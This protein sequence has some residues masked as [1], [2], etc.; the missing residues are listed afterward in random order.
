MSTLSLRIKNYL[1]LDKLSL[2]SIG[3]IVSILVIIHNNSFSIFY[4]LAL[5]GGV[6]VLV[7]FLRY[8]RVGLYLLI[9]NLPL[10]RYI[11]LFGVGGE[12]FSIS[13]NE[14]LML[15]LLLS[16]GIKK[17]SQGRLTVPNS[18]LN[19]PILLLVSFTAISLVKAFG[20]L[21]LADYA[22]C[23]LFFFLWAE[24]FLIIFLIL[25]LIR[26]D[27]QIKL[28]LGLLILAAMITVVSAIYQQLTGAITIARALIT[29]SGK[30]YYRTASTFGFFSNDYGAY[31]LV[32]LSIMLNLFLSGSKQLKRISLICILPTFYAFFYTFSRGGLVALVVMLIF[33]LILRKNQRKRLLIMSLAFGIIAAV[34][35]TPVF[36]RWSQQ[37]YLVKGGQFYFKKNI[38]ERL[39]QWDASLDQF[40]Q[41]PLLGKGFHTYHF[42]ELNF[43]SQYGL[44]DYIQHG[45]NIYLRLL[46]ESGVLGFIP[47][48]VL[49]VIIYKHAFRI[50]K[51]PVS[52]ELRWLAY[53]TLT[54]LTGF[55]VGSMMESLFTVGRVTGPLFA[56][57]G[58]LMVKSRMEGIDI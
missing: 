57:I 32:I 8:P 19:R 27:K 41:H 1:D 54:A 29:E 50:L 10:N 23:W 21:A 35:F 46:I 3:L 14:V 58:L 7:L 13:V 56:L 44:V 22:K 6:A 26:N 42:R 24:Y 9:F 12:S 34:I 38:S 52:E 49:I 39:A 47:F 2:I 31:L 11:P 53:V 43:R 33:L 20:E 18:K 36:L 17:L 25:D 15:F 48:L 40:K 55:L 37:T 51:K 4:L 28:I 30:A 5:L 16:L 45:H